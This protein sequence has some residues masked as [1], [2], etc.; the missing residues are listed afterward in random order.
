VA[1]VTKSSNQESNPKKPK[2]SLRQRNLKAAEAKEKPRRIR[3]AASNAVK[4]VGKVRNALKTE[5]HV[6]PQAE[7]AGFFSKSRKATPSYFVNAV[8]ELKQVSWPGRRETWK[9]VFAVFVFAISIGVFI[10][11]LDF[12]LEKLFREVIL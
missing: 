10:A 3:K 5:Y 9:L 4:P 2:T 12:G 1:K 8:G 6:F 11:I 7:D